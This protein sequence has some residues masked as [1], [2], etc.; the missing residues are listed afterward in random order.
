LTICAVR[1]WLLSAFFSCALAQQHRLFLG[2]I[3]LYQYGAGRHVLARF[4]RDVRDAPA[5]F[6]RHLYLARRF[7]FAHASEVAFLRAQHDGHECHLVAG[8][9][10]ASAAWESARG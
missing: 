8:V 5:R 6:G 10:A 4:K 3:Q 7:Q 2:V 9:A 1:A